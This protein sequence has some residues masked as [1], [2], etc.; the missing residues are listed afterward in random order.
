MVRQNFDEASAKLQAAMALVRRDGS[1]PD[2]RVAELVDLGYGPYQRAI[3][4]MFRAVDRGDAA[5][6]LHIDSE[7]VDPRFDLI[8][9]LVH[10]AADDRRATALADL[11]ELKRLEAATARLT[12]VVFLIG[13]VFVAFFSAVLGRTRTQLTQ[14]RTQAVHDALH[15]SLTGLPNRTLLADRFGQALIAGNRTSATTGLLLVDLDRFKEINDTLG[16]AV[17][18]KLLTQVG[19]RLEGALRSA[20]TIARLGGDE[21]AVLLPTVDG[22]D[23]A[24]DVAARLRAALARPFLIGDVELDVDGSIGLVVSGLHGRDAETLMQRAEVAMYVAKHQRTGIFV[25]DPDTDDHSLERLSLLGELRRGIERGELF[26]QYQPK[27]EL[28]TNEVVGVEALVRWRH[29]ERGLLHPDTFIP[30][31]EQTGMIGPLTHSVLDMALMQAREWA[32]AGRPVPVA[33]NISARN[34]AD[35][36]FSHE[37]KTLLDRHAVAAMLLEIEVT[38]SAVMLDAS[39]AREV[40]MDLHTIGVRVALDD[41]GAGYTSLAQLRDL[42]ISVLKI[43]KSFILTMHDEIHNALIVESMID[44]GHSLAM[45]VVAEGIETEATMKAL[46]DLDCDLGQGYH[47]CRPMFPEAFFAWYER[48][49]TRVRSTDDLSGRQIRPAG[50]ALLGT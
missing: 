22:L 19:P 20:D 48:Q 30:L 8:E 18:D 38:E 6:V 36:N 46:A 11:A 27:I 42:P 14:Q 44:L 41:F 24:M 4:E 39:M 3:D 25:Y 12:P 7:D 21:F 5:L 16:H 9:N 28:K 26:L 17:G 40:L 31:A 33:V 34:L 50:L 35:K 15:D 10:Q 2:L 43:D 23:G 37:V 47:L 13:F 1:A 49:P 32:D 45:K 29:P